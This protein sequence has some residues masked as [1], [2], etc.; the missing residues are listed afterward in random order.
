MPNTASNDVEPV[1]TSDRPT[2]LGLI[3]TLGRDQFSSRGLGR[4]A[5][6]FVAEF[7]RDA[8]G[9]RP[10]LTVVLRTQGKRPEALK[11]ALLCLAG[12]S[13]EDFEVIVAAHD[14]TVE[15]FLQVNEII[16]AQPASF[17]SRI[18]TL[19][20][21]GGR[22]SKPLNVA[23]EQARG[24]Y[25]SFFDDDD[26]LF[27]H[28]VESFAEMAEREPGKLVRAV[29]AS[30]RASIE[31][32]PQ[33]QTGFRH[34]NWPD[35]EYPAHF[36]QFAHLQMNFS[37]FMGWAFPREIF[38][39]LGLRFDEELYVC[40]DW[41][42]IL[43]ASLLCG[44]VQA[45][46]MTAI[47]RRWEGAESSYTTH[48]DT[49]WQASQARVIAKLNEQ[50]VIM[51]AGTVGLVRQLLADRVELGRLRAELHALLTSRSWRYAYPIREAMRVAHFARR[52]VYGVARRVKRLS[53]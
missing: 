52:A 41:D 37:P 48:D 23:V 42:L 5:D 13:N 53:R 14:A 19:E 45:P 29:V 2:L 43:R 28:W 18:S 31:M 30:Q 33:D 34:M 36:D 6:L 47:Y 35:A 15:D 21:R 39:V 50:A 3:R 1:V 22:R 44:V 27:G 38:D 40:E 16:A 11:D 32:W 9:V 51:P 20:V 8:E 49:Q 4:A 10:F 26:L 17:K 46:E 24:R 7:T 25:V 12:Q